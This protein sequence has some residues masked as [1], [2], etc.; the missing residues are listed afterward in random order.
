MTGSLSLT[1]SGGP[2]AGREILPNM[3][4]PTGEKV[5]L[6]A[7]SGRDGLYQLMFRPDLLGE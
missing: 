1:S 7:R 2:A 4:S 3:V 6:E 5:T